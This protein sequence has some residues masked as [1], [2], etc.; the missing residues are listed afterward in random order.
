M[1]ELRAKPGF[2]P[3]GKCCQVIYITQVIFLQGGALFCT[4]SSL[5]SSANHQGQAGAHED[6]NPSSVQLC[7]SVNIL[8]SLSKRD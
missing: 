1:S 3:L 5:M 2:T 8:N 6:S 7:I 4:V